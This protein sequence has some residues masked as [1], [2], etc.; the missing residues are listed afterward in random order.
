MAPS[1]DLFDVRLAGSAACLSC[2]LATSAN[3]DG[4]PA[5]RPAFLRGKL[6]KL[7][8]MRSSFRSTTSS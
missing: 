4:R 1:G 2:R 7:H 5:W 8:A 3:R 6:A